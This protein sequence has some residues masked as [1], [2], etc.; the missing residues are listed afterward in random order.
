MRLDVRR[1]PK[2]AV[3]RVQRL[4]GLVG[5]LVGPRQRLAI[6]RC[7]QRPAQGLARHAGHQVVHQFHIAKGLG[8]LLHAHVQEAVVHPVVGVALGV[9]G[10]HALGHL[11]L[12]V[13]EDQVVATAVDVD[14]QAQR[15]FDHRR[16][17]D[18]PA[19]PSRTEG[20]RPHRLARLRR[21]PEHEVGGV[22]LVRRDLH[23]GA[24]DHLV[25]R[26]ARELAVVGIGLGVEQHV[27]LG[28]V[29][30]VV[31]HQ[32]ADHV[33][34]RVH[35]LRGARLEGRRQR[36]QARHVGVVGVEVARRDHLDRHALVGGLL[37]D[38]VLA[39][40]PAQQAE[41]HV[42]RHHRPGVADVREVVD[43]RPADI[44]R[45]SVWVDR[46]EV[47]LL[48]GHGVVQA[49]VHFDY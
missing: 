35:R 19:G 8:H 13:G 40:Q 26:P 46:N 9:V 38:V 10:A 21:L 17:F 27:A 29:G 44:H 23:P 42:E 31:A 2:D 36:A 6:V 33:D 25:Q 4:P 14:G 30:G 43:R 32:P 39:I 1:S 20:A 49:Q 11:V 3:E 45:H 15:L 47:P 28:G 34:D 24:V 12:V 48:A 16:A 5:H 18:V 41:Q 7:Q 37:V 22:L